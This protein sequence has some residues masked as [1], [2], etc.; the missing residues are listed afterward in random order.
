MLLV[1]IEYANGMFDET[2]L[3]ICR[4]LQ[5]FVLIYLISP[6]LYN[7]NANYNSRLLFTAGR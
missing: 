1:F 6:N 3:K 4:S 7:L 5:S 2:Q